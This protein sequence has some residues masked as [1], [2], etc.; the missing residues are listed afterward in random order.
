MES[1]SLLSLLDQSPDYQEKMM[2]FDGEIRKD[3]PPG[4]YENYEPK[5]T[6]GRYYFIDGFTMFITV[7][8]IY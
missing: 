6:L 5:E 7:L 1:A 2:E 8:E 3:E 4:F